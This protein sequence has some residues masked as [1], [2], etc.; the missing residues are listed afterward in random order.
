M[1]K[2]KVYFTSM[3]VNAGTNLLKKLNHLVREAGIANID[4]E[5][6]TLLSK[7]I[8][9]N[10]ATLPICAQTMQRSSWTW[11]KNWAASLS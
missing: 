7:F 8:L 10:R 9:A 6:N 5:T 11:S 1:E 4:F 2:S 3:K